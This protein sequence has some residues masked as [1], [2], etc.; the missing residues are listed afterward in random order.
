[1][2]Y[3]QRRLHE[4]DRERLLR[5]PI[6]TRNMEILADP[7]FRRSVEQAQPY[8]L[9]DVGRLANLWTLARMTGPGTF[10]EVGSYR[11]GGALHLLHAMGARREP[12]YSFDPF[13]E[14]GF[15]KVTAVDNLFQSQDF[16]DTRYEKVVEL[17]K[18]FPNARV[19]RGFFPAA[20][21]G[22]DLGP[23]AFCHLDVD[24]YQATRD[25]LAYLA[26]RLARR[27]FIVL[28]DVQRS[29]KGVEKAV[30]EFLAEHPAFLFLPVFPSQGVLLSK[31]L[32]P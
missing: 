10:L 14:G 30:A 1:V 9:L 6:D 26:P 13:E 4:R 29:V 2:C 20:A 15:E 7:E 17:V 12:F 11:G 31:E 25:S 27:S 19:V 8:T 18:P 5:P 21:A 24:V 32:W 3:R 22:I 28:D 23:I 16:T